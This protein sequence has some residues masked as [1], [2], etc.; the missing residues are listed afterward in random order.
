MIWFLRKIVVLCLWYLIFL[1]AMLFADWFF[2]IN[3]GQSFFDMVLGGL[4]AFLVIG[5]VPIL[6]SFLGTYILCRTVTK[7]QEEAYFAD[8]VF[9]MMFLLLV[10]VMLFIH[11]YTGLFAV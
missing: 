2:S 11:S 10:I 3:S 4:V 6:L 5:F 7:L 1:G 9:G 8:A